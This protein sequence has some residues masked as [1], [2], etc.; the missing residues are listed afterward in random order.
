MK[1]SGPVLAVTGAPNSAIQPLTSVSRSLGL[2]WPGWAAVVNASDA[3]VPPAPSRMTTRTTVARFVSERLEL[4][5]LRFRLRRLHERERR[6]GD[7]RDQR[8]HERA[9]R[10]ACFACGLLFVG[11]YVGH[12][13]VTSLRNIL[14]K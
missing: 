5:L 12:H 9:A 13:L 6:G 1:Q 4:S 8:R 3:T 2:E 14:T 11:V 7:S 10:N